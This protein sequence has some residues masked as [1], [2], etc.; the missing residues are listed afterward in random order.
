MA[1]RQKNLLE[2]FNASAAIEKSESDHTPDSSAAGGPFAPEAKPATQAA[3][4]ALLTDEVKPSLVETLLHP[5]NRGGL[6]VL[7]ALGLTLAFLAGRASVGRV[8]AEESS[9]PVASREP[10]KARATLPSPSGSP[11]AEAPAEPELSQEA[12]TPAE[13]ALL[14]PENRYT[15]KLVEYSNS[16]RDEE[17]AWE[18]F[19]YLEDQGLPAA[20]LGRGQRLFIVLGAARQQAEL[21]DLLQQAKTMKGPPPRNK[22]AEFFDAYV[23]KIDKFIQR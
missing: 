18:T 20:V 12:Q 10:E 17:L 16:E 9:T 11:A 1:H 23:D 15:I 22:K 2:A 19:Y 5:E 3:P 21:D 13:R 4:P 6:L 7:V 8:E 14:D